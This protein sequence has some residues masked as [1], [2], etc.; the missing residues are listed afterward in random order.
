MP[1]K[2]HLNNSFGSP[3]TTNG[4]HSSSNGGGRASSLS[5]N[6]TQH[7]QQTH[8][9]KA[10]FEAYMMTGDL[11]LNLSRTAQSSELISNCEQVKKIDSLRNH[12]QEKNSRRSLSKIAQRRSGGGTAPHARY[13]S[14]P[15]SPTNDSTE[16]DEEIEHD[17]EAARRHCACVSPNYVKEG[18]GAG[19][20][21]INYW[22]R[23]VVDHQAQRA[24]NN[25]ALEDKQNHSRLGT[26]TN[27]SSAP[28]STTTTSGPRSSTATTTT[29]RDDGEENS[30]ERL[31]GGSQHQLNHQHQSSNG[32]SKLLTAT[33]NNGTTTGS[34][35]SSSSG[36]R[37]SELMLSDDVC[38]S[39]PTSPV[40]PCPVK[41]TANS[42]PTS[43]ETAG[44]NGDAV[45]VMR[46]QGGAS[47]AVN[48]MMR[49]CD[50]AGFRTSR[51]EDHLQLSQRDGGSGLGMV[52]IDIDEDVN[53]SLNTLLDTRHD[54][55]EDSPNAS[56]GGGGGQERIVWTYNAPVK[57]GQQPQYS[58]SSSMSSSPQH[59]GTPVSPTSVSSSVMSSNSSSKSLG[60]ANYVPHQQQQQ[61]VMPN[62][63]NTMTDSGTTCPDL[64]M[65]E[66]V[67]NIS[68]PDYQD[69][70]LL[71][72]S[73]D[74]LAG[75]GMV[76]SDPSDSDSTLMVSDTRRGGYDREN[77]LVI[78][79]KNGG[80][81]GIENQGYS[82]LKDSEDELATLTEDNT[83]TLQMGGACGA[84][85]GQD[86][87]SS[88][89]SD[90][91]SD[92][93]SLHSYHYSPKAVDM[94]SAIRLAKRLYGLDGFK[95]SDVSRHLSKK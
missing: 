52:P 77:K 36:E 29:S 87:D 65:S 55:S 34:S 4:R 46:R 76:V 44:N 39:A 56:S 83:P 48:G 25:N 79:V 1:E 49:T 94:P 66:A 91:G 45:V 19:E 20:K 80:G 93:E 8:Q 32:H 90:D 61:H 7:H 50:Q 47:G 72:S 75:G 60:S 15:S 12:S 68:S 23:D 89:V 73:R 70:N 64:S 92:V 30:G 81:G 28:T 84:F 74:M 42:V 41:S 67:S 31:I 59:T 38:F 9:N 88:P 85:G 16:I 13:D 37:S 63:R 33:T 53:S 43:P 18:C 82:E 10:R 69:D 57:P 86:R 27:N 62:Q 14:S 24:G 40:T 21:C 58:H 17:D 6:G 3:A 78:H 26:M 51:S 35:A 2:S 71:L 22:N 5:P 11:I 54:D 95:K